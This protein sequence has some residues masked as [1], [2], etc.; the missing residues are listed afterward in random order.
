MLGDDPSG[1]LG[2]LE[3]RG[4]EVDADAGAV[5]ELAIDLEGELSASWYPD[6]SA[7]LVTRVARA[8]ADLWRYD[9]GSGELSDLGLDRKSVV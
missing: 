5:E 8:R 7:L 9:L 1:P 2:I 6:A 4:A 3:S